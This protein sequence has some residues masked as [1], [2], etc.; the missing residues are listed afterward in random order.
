[1][2]T[3]GEHDLLVR[4]VRWEAE[5][6]VSIVLADPAGVA[7]P[8]WEPGAHLEV[9]LPSGLIRHYSLCGDPGDRDH[10]CIA[11]LHEPEGRGGSR[12]LHTSLLVGRT[13]RV[14]GPRN[15]FELVAAPRYLFVAGGIGITPILPM[16]RAVAA[17]TEPWHLVYRGRSRR[18]MAFLDEIEQLDTTRVEVLASDEI[19]RWDLDAAIRQHASS[20]TEVYCCGPDRLSSAVAAACLQSLG[21]AA[22]T[23][24]FNGAGLL[25]SEP[26]GER[27]AFQVHLQRTGVTLDVP[28]DRSILDLVHEVLPDMPS[29]CEEG[30]C[31][32]CEARVLEGVPEHHDTVLSEREREAGETMMI[33]VGRSRTPRLV[34]DL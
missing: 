18:T 9:V 13:L 24:R 32:S 27:T 34:L 19:S 3:G 16:V 31:G 5:N 1:M 29:S 22:H 8:A 11:V 6:V 23:E 7:L 30:Y 20:D 17:R 10:Y 25:P 33:C 2:I 28:A 12:E 21:R 4:S 26:G 14:R 15:H